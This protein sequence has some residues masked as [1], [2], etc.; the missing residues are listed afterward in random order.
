[1]ST[2]LVEAAAVPIILAVQQREV[3]VAVV[4]VAL[5]PLYLVSQEYLTRAAAAAE[6]LTMEHL[7]LQLMVAPVARV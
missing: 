1:L 7:E 4:P 3:S 6:V 2:T 5:Y